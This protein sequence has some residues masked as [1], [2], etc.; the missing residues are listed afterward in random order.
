MQFCQNKFKFYLKPVGLCTGC[1]IHY[2]LFISW[3]VCSFKYLSRCCFGWLNMLNSKNCSTY[4]TLTNGLMTL[5]IMVY[6]W[7]N[8]MCAT[9]ESQRGLVPIQLLN[10][11]QKVNFVQSMI[12]NGQF[13]L[14]DRSKFKRIF[15]NIK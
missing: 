13:F 10:F 1:T 8:M 11:V 6:I 7:D 15:Y 4:F 12:R 14:S 5:L 3:K 9:T 2:F